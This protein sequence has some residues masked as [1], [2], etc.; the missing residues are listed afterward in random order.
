LKENRLTLFDDEYFNSYKKLGGKK[1]KS[2][3]MKILEIFF[4]ETL[5]IFIDGNPLYH[6]SREEA[7]EAVKKEAKITYE[8][9]DL[10]F[11]S[12]D[13]VTAYT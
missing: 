1:N 2:R 9:L 11:E 13:D 6:D 5:D 8:E 7:L 10:I 12:V 4:N 3:Y